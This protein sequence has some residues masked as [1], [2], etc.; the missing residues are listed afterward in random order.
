MTAALSTHDVTLR[1]G[2]LVAVNNVNLSI[3][4][5]E[6]FAV[7]GP[8]GAGKTSLFNAI[9]G[10]YPATSGKICVDGLEPCL[11]PTTNTG[12]QIAYVAILTGICCLLV[13]N[14]TGVWQASINDL[15][16]YGHSFSWTT[17]LTRAF[18][19][20]AQQRITNTALPFLLGCVVGGLAALRIWYSARRNTE[21][22]SRS[23]LSRTF[24]NVRLFPQLSAL[25]NVLI[26]M[27]AGFESGFF[28]SLLRLPSVVREEM[29][30]TEF[31]L[32]LL[33]F[34]GL[35]GYGS[36]I[37]GSLPYGSQRRLEIAR[38][39]ASKPKV[40]LLD[41]PAAGMN[42]TESAKLMDIIK[43]IRESPKQTT[44]IV[45][46]EHDMKVVMGISD[47]VAVLDYGSLIACGTPAQIRTDSK[48]I[49]AY[50]GSLGEGD[51]SR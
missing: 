42:P 31:A 6:I 15:F 34:V 28:A 11:Q 37:A 18:G 41:E 38:A 25:D 49:T 23:G 36:E 7:I 2:G 1:F 48:V 27:H 50:L 35:D 47:R 26:G 29:R 51:A 22:C 19:Y 9:S 33:K 40:L 46:I 44:T 17:S 5:G 14:I 8:N 20:L 30:A 12:S 45:L 21:V 10:I 39:L 4:H 32:E 24:Q 43:G 16:L 13:V 3:N